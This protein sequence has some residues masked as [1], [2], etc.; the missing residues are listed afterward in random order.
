MK[1]IQWGIIGA[2]H[3]AEAMAEA[4]NKGV[5]NA[6]LYGVASTDLN[7]G[8]AFASKWQI[9]HVYSSYQSL[10]EDPEVQIVYIATPHMNH[11][12]LSIKAMKNGKAVICEKPGAVNA[13]QLRQV[14]AVSQE[15]GMFYM[16]ALWS[17]FQP[18]YLRAMEWIAEGKIGDLKAIHSS[19]CINKP[20]VANYPSSGYQTSRLYDPSLAGGALLDLGIYT[21]TL[22]LCAIRSISKTGAISGY[23][24]P[25]KVQ[26]MAHIG[27]TGVDEYET[28]SLQ[29]NTMGKQIYASLTNGITMEIHLETKSAQILGSKAAIRMKD[30]WHPQELELCSPEGTI[31]ER[32][33]LP[34]EVNG[35]EYEAREITDIVASEKKE[36]ESK[37]HS[38]LQSLQCLQIMD[39]LRKDWKLVYPFE[40]NI[41]MSSFADSVKPTYP[42]ESQTSATKTDRDIVVYTDGA[43]SGNPGSGGW[44]AVI[45]VDGEEI[46]LSDGEKVTT[47]NRMELMAAISSLE[48]IAL[49][50]DW[51]GRDISV[52]IDSQYVKNGITTWIKSW[53]K[54]G[55]KT[56]N[57][58]PVKNKD[59][60]MEL[61]ELVEGLSL[62]WVWVKGHAGNKY[63]EICDELAV[64]AGKKAALS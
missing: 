27:S 56:A 61:D 32:V 11:A 46:R 62:R 10:L 19:F 22:A 55:W 23:I 24:L 64:S 20:N 30:F 17:K 54:N 14:L 37:K 18:C 5:A 48:K 26:S 34:F 45:L 33:E 3:I 58:E 52:Y 6:E 12:E 25:S 35:Y 7:R 39:S 1:K 9:P 44:G 8:K 15:T 29:F 43:C 31:L 63:N 13:A 50:P 42:T 36:I 21:L 41:T 47:N 2:G 40:E 49:N 59:L 4:V 38:H 28:I 51:A 60:W 16:E 53:K 57:K